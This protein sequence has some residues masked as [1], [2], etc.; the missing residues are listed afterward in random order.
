MPTTSA[1]GATA[2]PGN[3]LGL[4]LDVGGTATRWALAAAA[5]QI[6]AE[7]EIGGMPGRPRSVQEWQAVQRQLAALSAALRPHLGVVGSVGSAG[8]AGLAGRV[9][10]VVAGITGFDA[11][12]AAATTYRESCAAAL[13]LAPQRIWLADDIVM[14]CL[15]QFA[16]GDGYL[17]YAGTGS[18]SAYVDEQ[19]ALHRAGGRG[20]V[21]DDAGSAVW[22]VC[23]AFK[24]IW[25]REDEAPGSWQQ[26]AL[27]RA[28]LQGVGGSDWSATRSFI[29]GHERGDI[30]RLA[31]EIARCADAD[32]LAAELLQRAGAELAR[33]AQVHITRHGRR[34]VVL[35]GRGAG[36]HPNI[37]A[38]MQA[39]LGPE[40]TV[41]YR[42]MRMHLKAAE[43][44]RDGPQGLSDL[45]P[46]LRLR[47][48]PS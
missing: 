19:G 2:S 7:G 3:A 10:G 12:T 13:G 40:I 15:S 29:Y 24:A 41:S 25:R 37:L 28:L 18:M 31:L 1:T 38:T 39:R 42:A 9:A 6:V 48:P 23:Q 5:G 16:P 33:L 27:A 44:A 21:L 4:G 46:L 36:L 45:L 22:M 43:F 47:R 26:S 32:P 17:V 30:G 14:G 35:S 8:S 34:P 11:S 20:H